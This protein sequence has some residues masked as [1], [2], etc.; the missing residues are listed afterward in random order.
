MVPV[1]VT[2]WTTTA[3]DDLAENGPQGEATQA[4]GRLSEVAQDPESHGPDYE[5]TSNDDEPS[6]TD[7]EDDTLSR[8]S[9]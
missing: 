1:T 9:H 6:D 5:M 4:G 8:I 7:E 3:E 2:E